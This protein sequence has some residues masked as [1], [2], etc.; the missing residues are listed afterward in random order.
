MVE[1]GEAQEGLDVLYLSRF[2]P[3]GDGLDLV[4]RH[5]KSGS[6]PVGGPV[7]SGRKQMKDKGRGLDKELVR[8][9]LVTAWIQ[10]LRIT[11]VDPL[12][13]SGQ[14]ETETETEMDR[15]WSR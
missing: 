3:V 11:S 2:R 8:P 6:T 15:N 5:V 1:V 10:Q 14:E 9:E 7:K 4:R 12:L 13:G